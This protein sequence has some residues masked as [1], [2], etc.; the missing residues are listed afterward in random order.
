M[1]VDSRSE[2][3]SRGIYSTINNKY[4]GTKRRILKHL[5]FISAMII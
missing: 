2:A 5:G 4:T 1:A 3:V